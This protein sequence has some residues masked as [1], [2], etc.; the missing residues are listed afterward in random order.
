MLLRFRQIISV[1]GEIPQSSD[2]PNILCVLVYSTVCGEDA[3]V[4]NVVQGHLGP[5]VLVGVQLGTVFLYLTIAVEVCQNH[6]R[7]QCPQRVCH[8]SELAAVDA[9]IHAVDT[10]LD[11]RIVVVIVLR[12]IAAGLEGVDFLGLH[13]EDEDI[14]RTNCIAD[15]DVCTVQCTL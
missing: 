7:I 1:P 15:F 9:G 13:A 4:G 12:T 11:D 2:I 5:C 3:C 6:V 10:A 14:F 8:F